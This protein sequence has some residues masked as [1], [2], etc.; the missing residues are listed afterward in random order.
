MFHNCRRFGGVPYLGFER[1]TLVPIQTKMVDASLMSPQE[2]AW[3][4]NYHAEV[5]G[6]GVRGLRHG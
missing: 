1:L 2:V 5:R 6:K 4:D 3:L